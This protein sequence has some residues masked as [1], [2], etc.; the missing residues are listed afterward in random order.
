M[1]ETL[2]AVVTCPTRAHLR[3]ISLTGMR[4]ER[5]C[6]PLD[7]QASSLRQSKAWNCLTSPLNQSSICPESHFEK[8]AVSGVAISGRAED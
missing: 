8:C 5:R 3:S 4:R 7:T 6:Q 1:Q 2:T